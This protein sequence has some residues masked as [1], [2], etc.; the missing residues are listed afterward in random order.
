MVFLGAAPVINT[1]QPLGLR[2]LQLL[3]YALHPVGEAPSSDWNVD[4][5]AAL[6][7][8]HAT[9]GPE[10]VEV[11]PRRLGPDEADVESFLRLGEALEVPGSR[12]PAG[13]LQALRP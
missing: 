9:A 3:H 13:R 10:D 5:A 6:A 8:L 12:H 7:G 1:P 2:S 11:L 4:S